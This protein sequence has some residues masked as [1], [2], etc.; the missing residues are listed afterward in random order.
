MPDV[1]LFPLL[2]YIVGGWLALSALFTVLVIAAGV[3]RASLEELRDEEQERYIQRA[4]A[5]ID[6]LEAIPTPGPW[7]MTFPDA[8][9]MG[10]SDGLGT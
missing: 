3:R 4:R 1:D 8:G 10:R 5:E 9:D 7:Q 2:P 6:R